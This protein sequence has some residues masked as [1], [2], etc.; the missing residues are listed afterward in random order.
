MQT[1]RIEHDFLGERAIDGDVY[2]G[3]QTLRAIENFHITGIPLRVEP[4]FVQALAYVK[5]AAA[6]ANRDYNRQNQSCI[7][8]KRIV[9]EIDHR[10]M[11]V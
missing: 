4:L 10:L 5:K 9:Y 1:T 6:L 3:I 7:S 11:V 8:A 2:Y